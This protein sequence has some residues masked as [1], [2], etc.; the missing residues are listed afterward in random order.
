MGSQLLEI[1]RPPFI[2]RAVSEAQS[3]LAACSDRTSKNGSNE[4]YTCMRRLSG[5]LAVDEADFIGSLWN[6]F[7]YSFR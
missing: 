3:V 5:E 6:F 4:H 1:R 2:K 7:Y